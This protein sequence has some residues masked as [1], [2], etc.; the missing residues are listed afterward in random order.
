MLLLENR[1]VPLKLYTQNIPLWIL[2]GR[3]VS[4]MI[5]VCVKVIT[6]VYRDK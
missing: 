3:P 2:E 5:V 1:L 4:L 6:L